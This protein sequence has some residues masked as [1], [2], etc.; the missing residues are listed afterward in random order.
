MAKFN[1]AATG[2]E[3]LRAVIEIE[4][5]K[6][7]ALGKVAENAEIKV[8]TSGDGAKLLGVPMNAET[9]ANL[10]QLLEGF[11]LDKLTALLSTVEDDE[12]TE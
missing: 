10:G 4:Q 9:G 7:D 12:E 5:A 2:I 3:K 1:E 8:V 6:Y 11:G